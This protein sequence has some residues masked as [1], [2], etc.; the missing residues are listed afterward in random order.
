MRAA[1]AGWTTPTDKPRQEIAAI[2]ASTALLIFFRQE[3]GIDGA[4]FEDVPERLIQPLLHPLVASIHPVGADDPARVD[5]QAGGNT[6]G[7]A[8]MIRLF[9]LSILVRLHDHDDGG[10]PD[11]I[12]FSGFRIW[13]IPSRPTWSIWRY[14]LRKAAYGNWP[15]PIP[16]T[17]N[18]PTS[19]P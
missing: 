15:P 16:S 4:R 7:I 8:G 12:G 9:I 14:D 18:S 17:T 13:R 1:P 2:D 6:P 3:R 10:R 5:H 11:A 19:T